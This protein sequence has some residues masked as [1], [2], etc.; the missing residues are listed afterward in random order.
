MTVSRGQ[1]NSVHMQCRS[2]KTGTSTSKENGLSR[3]GSVEKIWHLKY[4]L[5]RF[6]KESDH[7][8]FT[9][10]RLKMFGNKLE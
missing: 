8:L 3:N 6:K 4:Q 5:R 9:S 2:M 10:N 7:L 1:N